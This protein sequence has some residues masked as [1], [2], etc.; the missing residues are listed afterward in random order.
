[1]LEVRLVLEVL[2]LEVLKVLVLMV[3]RV[4]DAA[5]T[6]I[7]IARLAGAQGA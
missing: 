1:M 5:R 7:S 6:G 2:V 4:L 3:R